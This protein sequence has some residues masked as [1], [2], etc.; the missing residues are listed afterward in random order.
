MTAGRTAFPPVGFD[1]LLLVVTGALAAA[2]VPQGLAWLRTTYPDLAVRV[3]LT[4]AAER[5]VS[6]SALGVVSGNPIEPDTW[7]DAPVTAA[8]HVVLAEWAQAIVV[9]P[10]TVHYV[11]RLALGLADTPSLLAL[12]CT[13][14]PVAVAPAFP[15]GGWDNPLLRRHVTALEER[16]NIAVVPPAPARSWTT[17]RDDAYGAAPFPAVLGTVELRRRALAGHAPDLGGEDGEDS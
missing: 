3:V 15:P 16:P 4:R 11:S 7:P 12:Q 1:R 2:F 17:G 8:P 5:F 9:Y 13:R 14:A 6:P 10:A